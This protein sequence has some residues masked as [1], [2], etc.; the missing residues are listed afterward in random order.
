MARRKEYFN[1]EAY[2][3]GY[4]DGCKDQLNKACEVYSEELRQIINIL[5]TVGEMR[6]I[7]ELGD[8][9]SFEGCVRDFR[10]AMEEQ[11]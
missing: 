6:G 2:N 11:L 9:L 8:I 7:E 3:I 10:K 1:N 5:N 4:E